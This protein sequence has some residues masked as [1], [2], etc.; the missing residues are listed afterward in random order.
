MH[1]GPLRAA[2]EITK[3]SSLIAKNATQAQ[4]SRCTILL[5]MSQRVQFDIYVGLADANESLYES[6]KNGRACSANLIWNIKKR[7]LVY[8]STNSLFSLY[9][10]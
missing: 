7:L 6:Q 5:L 2:F 1:I 9:P 3:V 8:R 4:G 10:S